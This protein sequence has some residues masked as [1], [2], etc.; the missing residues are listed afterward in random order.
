MGKSTQAA[1]LVGHLNDFGVSAI[2]TREPGGVPLSEEIR[3]IVLNLP[4]IVP[5]AQL[6]LFYAARVE[7]VSN[8]IEPNLKEGVTVVSDRFSPSSFVY[9]GYVQGVDIEDIKKLD[10]V[11]VSVRPDIIILLDG[12]PTVGQSR[13][14]NRNGEET[15][16][17]AQKLDFHQKVRKG[18]LD[19]ARQDPER[20]VVID[21]TKSETEVFNTLLTALRDRGILQKE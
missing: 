9:Q 4:G 18:F 14:Q 21:G 11:A 17:D 7:L 19:L 6:L 2:L 15:V 10:S 5:R 12:N 3:E 8:V 13:R 1:R 16:F 20:W